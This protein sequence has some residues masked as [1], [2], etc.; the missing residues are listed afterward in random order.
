MTSELLVSR[1]VDLSGSLQMEGNVKISGDIQAQTLYVKSVLI[2]DKGR[3]LARLGG[4]GGLTDAE[5]NLTF[6]DSRGK[7]EIAL[8][9][10]DSGASLVLH[11]P[12]AATVLLLSS[13]SAAN[14]EAG[15]SIRGVDGSQR[16]DLSLSGSQADGSP[17]TSLKL[18]SAD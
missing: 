17:S 15:L 11:G 10:D 6:Y 5:P 4:F 7:Q 8:E 12:N 16:L 13:A 18:T 1:K 14:E 2:Q 3:T 9:A